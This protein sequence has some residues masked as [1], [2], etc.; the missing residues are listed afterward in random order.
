MEQLIE[1]L[2]EILRPAFPGAE[3]ELE[4]TVPGEK[5]GGFVIWNG[6][7]AMEQIDR[8]QALWKVLRPVLDQVSA[9]S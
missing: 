4:A 6:F 8:Q 3:L 7:Q 5:V 2:K 9:A 1:Q